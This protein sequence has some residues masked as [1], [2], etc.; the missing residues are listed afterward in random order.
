MLDLEAS[1]INFTRLESLELERKNPFSK[2]DSLAIDVETEPNKGVVNTIKITYTNKCCF[3]A[4]CDGLKNKLSLELT[5]F[6]LMSLANFLEP[7]TLVDTY[8]PKHLAC[9][10]QLV[11]YLPDIKLHFFIGQYSGNKWKTT[12]D[13]SV[14]IG[15]GNEII[16]ILNKGCHFEFIKTCK[17]QFVRSSNKSSEFYIQ[18]QHDE[19]QRIKTYF[20][21]QEMAKRLEEEDRLEFNKRNTLIEKD[22]QLASYLQNLQESYILY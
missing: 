6:D 12:P 3:I 19:E 8:N 16:R 13:P 14:I 17:N 20:S 4:I 11:E 2:F 9:L 22:S 21:D 1:V 7:D 5:P 15:K 18:Q 10:E